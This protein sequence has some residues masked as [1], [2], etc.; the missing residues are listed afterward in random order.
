MF[1][2]NPPGTVALDN[3]VDTPMLASWRDGVYRLKPLEPADMHTAS[4]KFLPIPRM[5]EAADQFPMAALG[6]LKR[7]ERDLEVECSWDKHSE[8]V[9]TAWIHEFFPVHL[10]GPALVALAGLSNL[11]PYEGALL[12]EFSFWGRF[13]SGEPEDMVLTVP[14]GPT[15]QDGLKPPSM[16]KSFKITNCVNNL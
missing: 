2:L 4:L 7:R 11:M 5:A 6:A 14:V 3:G 9:V 12:D 8:E 13:F 15:D 1:S 10:V 16:A